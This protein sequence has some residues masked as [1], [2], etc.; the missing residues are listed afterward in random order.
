MNIVKGDKV[1]MTNGLERVNLIGETFEVAN[2]TETAVVLRDPNTKVAICSVDIDDFDQ[3]FEKPEYVKGWTCWKELVDDNFNTYAWYRSR[4]KKGKVE[5]KI[6]Y[7]QTDTFIRKSATCSQGDVFNLE[8]GIRLAYNRC[9]KEAYRRN[10]II[11]KESAEYYEAMLVE[12]KNETNAMIA[13]LYGDK[14][15]K[16]N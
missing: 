5:V 12:N 16:N 11:M 4:P 8:F 7:G 13:S 15:K 1:V 6:R 10:L 14:N 3:H 2:I 9:M